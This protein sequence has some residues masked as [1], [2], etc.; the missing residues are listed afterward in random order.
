MDRV[1]LVFFLLD[2][3]RREHGVA[4]A[5]AERLHSHGMNRMERVQVTK[6]STTSTVNNITVTDLARLRMAASMVADGKIL[7]RASTD[8]AQQHL[9]RIRLAHASMALG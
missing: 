5:A 4:E 9:P 8:M 6:V 3:W 1:S 2:Q 7:D